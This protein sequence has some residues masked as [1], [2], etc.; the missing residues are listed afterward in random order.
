MA[1]SPWGEVQFKTNKIDTT[2]PP[3]PGEGTNLNLLQSLGGFYE[4]FANMPVGANPPKYNDSIK[5]ASQSEVVSDQYYPQGARR[6]MRTWIAR[7]DHGFG[8]WGMAITDQP[9]VRV[10]GEMWMRLACKFPSNYDPTTGT[11]RLKWFRMYRNSL[12]GRDADEGSEMIMIQPGGWIVMSGQDDA[13]GWEGGFNDPVKWINTGARLNFGSW[14]MVE[15]YL[16]LDDTPYPGG[17]YA[18]FKLWVDGKFIGEHNRQRTLLANSNASHWYHRI[19]TYWN[20][21][22]APFAQENWISHVTFGYRGNLLNGGSIDT[23][24]AMDRD[25]NGFPFLGLATQ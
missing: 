24:G 5:E 23:T 20:K 19:H 2:L 6:S 11:G 8:K 18:S 21:P 3:E 7:G 17:P 1:E 14:N 10:R 15:G 12:D 13:P 16:R 4:N 9:Q 25:E 22:G